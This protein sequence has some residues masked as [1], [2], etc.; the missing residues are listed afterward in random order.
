MECVVVV[1]ALDGGSPFFSLRC[2]FFGLDRPPVP[3]G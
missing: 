3:W 2:L 1:C